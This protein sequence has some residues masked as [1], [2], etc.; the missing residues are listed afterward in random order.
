M[1]LF[2]IFLTIIYIL[3]SF[4]AQANQKYLIYFVDKGKYEK[5]TW[6]K[7]QRLKEDYLSD[8]ALSRRNQRSVPTFDKGENIQD[9]PLDDNYLK[10]L[11]QEGFQ[12]HGQLRWFNA[13]SG[14][15]KETVIEKIK[16]FPFVERV[17]PVIK[18]RFSKKS[19]DTTSYQL[20]LKSFRRLYSDLDYGPSAV[21]IQ[22]H[23]ID[24]LHG[25]NLTGEGVIMGVFDTG[26][27]LENPSLQHVRSQLMA[28]YD[29]IQGDSVTSNQEGDLSDQDS[30]GTFVLSILGGWEL[31][32]LVGPAF[33]ASYI[34]AKTEIVDKEIH[35]E[36]DNW[37]LA[38]EWA[39]RLG[40]D[41]VSS[42]LNYSIFDEGEFDYSYSDMDGKTT[43]ITR[44][45]NE[46]A[47]RGVLVVSSAGNQ[48]L[49]NFWYKIVAP[50]DGMYVL[51]VGAL[52]L[53]NEVTDFSCRGPSADGRI[54][55]DV[56]ALGV[57][58]YG[59]AVRQGYWYDRG[60]SVS[61]PL[62]AGIA[63]QLLQ[64]YPHLNLLNLLDIIRLSGDNTVHPDNDRGWGK[65]DAWKALNIV[66][67]RSYQLPQS[68]SALPV[69]PNPY[70]RG[71]GIIF[72][73]VNLSKAL[74]VTIKIYNTLG[75]KV[76]ELFYHGMTAHNLFP[77]D[78]RNSYGI[79]V[80][81][82]VYIYRISTP[83]WMIDGKLVVL[84]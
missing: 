80:S 6:E 59:A 47:R 36:E 52:E 63:A 13:V 28:E 29:F 66:K 73:P 54:K 58:V 39:E 46:L 12:I 14:N 4:E 8:R 65:V 71:S 72:F 70:F 20:F 50:A 82:G 1:K 45:A 7:R 48:D 43:L 22:F 35:L 18:W 64:G 3:F 27:S 44:A 57:R 21:Q 75:Q 25:E 40:V 67:D 26:F 15:A 42:S 9:L 2:L 23:N 10:F 79:P 76:T 68:N 38:A 30:H 34:L 51:A 61:C 62:V 81:A 74:P 19:L 16:Q 53:S 56:A 5:L 78:G 84:K 41:I 37:V 32:Q 83:K 69:R 77:W 17:E 33:K 24:R 31:G 11:E 49:A 55:P 60:T